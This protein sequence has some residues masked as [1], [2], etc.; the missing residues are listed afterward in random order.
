MFGSLNE[1]GELWRKYLLC[2]SL[3]LEPDG[4]GNEAYR[5]GDV[6]FSSIFVGHERVE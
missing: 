3:L 5:K 1:P 4:G 6:V 2:I